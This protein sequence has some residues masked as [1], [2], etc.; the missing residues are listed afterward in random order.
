HVDLPLHFRLAAAGSD[1][2]VPV[3]RHG[4]YGLPGCSRVHLLVLQESHRGTRRSVSCDEGEEAIIESRLPAGRPL[5]RQH[6]VL[7]ATGGDYRSLAGG[8][9][10]LSA[11]WPNASRGWDGCRYRTW[12]GAA[13]A[14]CASNLPSALASD[15]V[16]LPECVKPDRSC[17]F[18]FSGRR[19]NRF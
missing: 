16:G 9:V 3:L 12:S 13:G 5:V 8:R 14:F 17:C 19:P 15:L 2:S 11:A 10:A 1:R 18:R 6:A 4:K 7:S